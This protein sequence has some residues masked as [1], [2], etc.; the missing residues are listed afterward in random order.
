MK[1]VTPGVSHDD[2]WCLPVSSTP[3]GLTGNAVAGAHAANVADAW[4]KVGLTA[5]V[6][7]Q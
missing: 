5:T 6:C 1:Q 3:E 7:G 2:A 4:E